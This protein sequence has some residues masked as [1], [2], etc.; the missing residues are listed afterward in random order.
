MLMDVATEPTWKLR[1][2][3]RLLLATYILFIVCGFRPSS[4][5]KKVFWMLMLVMVLMLE[6]NPNKFKFGKPI[7]VKSPTEPRYGKEVELSI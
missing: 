2:C 1:V 3:S 4:E 7:K 5:L 6:V